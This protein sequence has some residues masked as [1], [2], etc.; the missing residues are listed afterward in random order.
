VRN[1]VTRRRIARK[2]TI[3]CHTTIGSMLL[4]PDFSSFFDSNLAAMFDSNFT[5]M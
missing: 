4:L 3:P 1:S 2:A 5:A